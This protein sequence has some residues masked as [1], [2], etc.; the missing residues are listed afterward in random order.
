[1]RGGVRVRDDGSV[2]R[3]ARVT[4]NVLLRSPVA[5][6]ADRPS[7]GRHASDYRKDSSHVHA[8]QC[9]PCRDHG[10]RDGCFHYGAIRQ[11]PCMASFRKLTT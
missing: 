5:S 11:V 3:A 6:L 4:R 2:T 9:R 8:D 7:A 1:M 10:T